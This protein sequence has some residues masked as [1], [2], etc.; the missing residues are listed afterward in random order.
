[1]PQPYQ[2]SPPAAE[3]QREY[4]LSRFESESFDALA[5]LAIEGGAPPSIAAPDRPLTLPRHE[6]QNCAAEF[7]AGV[8][9]K[10]GEEAHV[11]RHPRPTFTCAEKAALIAE[12]PDL[13]AAYG[14]IA[15]AQG[16]LLVLSEKHR[17]ESF[18][19]YLHD[20]KARINFK[21]L[22]AQCGVGKKGDLRMF[23]G[24]PEEVQEIL[25]L[26]PGSIS[27]LVAPWSKLS[28]I[29][30]DEALVSAAPDALYDFAFADDKSILIRPGVLLFCLGQHPYF[31][32]ILA[33]NVSGSPP[34]RHSPPLPRL[35]SLE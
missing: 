10:F 8:L 35:D 32:K 5:R 6:F 18:M 24:P 30:F 11:V 13:Y 9:A 16:T 14:P 12:R 15:V 31:H 21:L 33:K 26:E 23:R 22:K 2:T 3:D 27:P 1:M 19:V 28:V 17:P 25:G 4:A 29:R 20:G 34:G 7:V